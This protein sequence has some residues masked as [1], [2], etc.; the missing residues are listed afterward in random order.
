MKIEKSN[1]KWIFYDV[2]RVIALWEVI[3]LAGIQAFWVLY[4]GE[5]FQQETTIEFFAIFAPF[6][7]C[8][9]P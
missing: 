4:S 7:P 6:I 9:I 8:F 1:Y 5:T 3:L 2:I